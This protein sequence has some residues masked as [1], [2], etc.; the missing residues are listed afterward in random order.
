MKQSIFA[1]FMAF[2]FLAGCGQTSE[3]HTSGEQED[4]PAP[5]DAVIELPEKGEPNEEIA[6][7]VTVS[8]G[9]KPVE[10]ANEVK[11]EIWKEG[12]NDAS[13]QVEAMHSENGKYTSTYTF[14][15]DG[16]YHVQ[17]HV[18]A[19]DMH[20]MPT[21]TI[22][23]GKAEEGQHEHSEDA[24]EEGH[25][26]NGEVGIQ[27]EKPEVIKAKGQTPLAV[28]LEKDESPLTD[29]RVRLEIKKQGSNP[30]WV[31][32]EE[33]AEGEYKSD[34]QFPSGGTYLITIHVQ[35]D[36]GLHEHTEVEV[37]VE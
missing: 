17:S 12:K 19:R 31:D 8:Q 13:E 33:A 9:E 23:I 35:N 3:N 22:Q 2:I 16:L 36:A 34:Y 10:D 20:T 37:T 6:L 5:I 1:I 21:E 28:L 26:H 11:F 29:A 4:A 7:A 14:L 18:T 32:M 30:A 15:E 25:H 27:L 24:A